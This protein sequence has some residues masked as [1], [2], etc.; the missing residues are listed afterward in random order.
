MP[1]KP[2]DKVMFVYGFG[3]IKI[4]DKI[5]AHV[6]GIEQP[7]GEWDV[8]IDG[9]YGCMAVYGKG[10][11]P[12]DIGAQP[13]QPIQLKVNGEPIMPVFADKNVVEFS[14]YGMPKDNE[15]EPKEI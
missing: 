11:T 7:I 2:T 6:E 5:T 13:G 3:P 8:V 10:A 15:D 14:F 9:V 4:G 1:V 12:E